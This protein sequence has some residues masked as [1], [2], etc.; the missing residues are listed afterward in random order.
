LGGGVCCCGAGSPRIAGAAKG[1]KKQRY[2]NA[3]TGAVNNGM[4]RRLSLW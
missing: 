1:I 4:R 3:A 2:A